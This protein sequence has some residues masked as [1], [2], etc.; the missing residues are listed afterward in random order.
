MIVSGIESRTVKAVNLCISRYFRPGK[1]NCLFC[2][3]KLLKLAGG[4]FPLV[5]AKIGYQIFQKP[6]KHFECVILAYCPDW[7]NRLKELLVVEKE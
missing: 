6:E 1:Q 5:L 3:S 2:F 4:I 7:K